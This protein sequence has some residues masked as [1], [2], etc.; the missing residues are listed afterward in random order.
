[1]HASY[2]YKNYYVTWF[3]TYNSIIISK[4][5]NIMS[6]VMSDGNRKLPVQHV[7]QRLFSQSIFFLEFFSIST[8][9]VWDLKTKTCD[10]SKR[11]KFLKKQGRTISLFSIKNLEKII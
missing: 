4:V 7:L 3:L 8:R 9:N 1:M 11:L 5:I 2:S 10:F 6:P